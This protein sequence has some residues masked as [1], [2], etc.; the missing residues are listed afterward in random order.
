MPETPHHLSSAAGAE[1]PCSVPVESDLHDQHVRVSH[2]QLN[3]L[4]SHEARG[5]K[6]FRIPGPNT[7][8][9]Y[10]ERQSE[11]RLGSWDDVFREPAED[12]VLECET[13]T[14]QVGGTL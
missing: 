10:K 6:P 12:D 4:S 13:S 8:Q 1:C 7:Q 11:L 9:S 14:S 3:D 5:E 2:E